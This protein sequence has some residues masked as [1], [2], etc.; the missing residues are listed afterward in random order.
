MEGGDWPEAS[1]LAE[2]GLSIVRDA[3]LD[4]YGTSGL[5]YG[6]AARLAIHWGDAR[7]ARQALAEARRLRARLMQ[8]LPYLAVQARLELAR[9]HIAL[10][11]VAGASTALREV[12]DLLRRR[13]NLG[14]LARD[15]GELRSRLD[16]LRAKVVGASSL[17]AAE[18]RLLPWLATHHSF[19]EIGV[20]LRLSPHTVKSQAMAIYRKFGVSSRSQAIQLASNLGLLA[21]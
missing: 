17:T 16:G 13:P 2:Q 9:A 8:T 5:L 15:A 20:Q 18:L 1:T 4:D 21:A 12:E 14:V 11:D 19:H 10:T 7:R 6:A 3:H